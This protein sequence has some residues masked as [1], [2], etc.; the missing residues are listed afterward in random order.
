MAKTSLLSVAGAGAL[1][2][3]GWNQAAHAAPK[4]AQ[5][6]GI[7][8]TPAG[9]QLQPVGAGQGGGLKGRAQFGS[10][11]PYDIAYAYS[12]GRTL[13]T[14]D[15]DSPG[16]SKCA[17]DC[18]KEWPAAI[19]PA[20]ARASGEW[21]VIK[22]K[23]GVPQWAYRGRPLY[24][25]NKDKVPGAVGGKLDNPADRRGSR[26]E[27]VYTPPPPLPKGWNVALFKPGA[28]VPTPPGLDLDEVGDVNG[29]VLRNAEGLTIYAYDGNPNRDG[30]ACAKGGN[31]GVTWVPVAAP[32]GATKAIGEFSP[33]LRQDGVRQW[34]F[35]GKAL[36]TF[37]GDLAPRYANGVGVDA[38]WTPA[39]V[40]TFFLPAGVR[41]ENTAGQGK[42]LATPNGQTLYRRDAH[43]Y[44]TGGGHSLR[45]GVVM[46]PAVGRQLGTKVCEGS[47][48]EKW[49]PFFASDSDQPSG[50]WE[51]AQRGDGSRQWAYRGFPLYTYVG[52]TKP[53][54]INGN[55]IYEMF[56]GSDPNAVN[57]VGTEQV[58]IATLYWALAIP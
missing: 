35:R 31:C 55:D 5:D 42:I 21:S 3:L 13:Y 15:E 4:P 1:L 33:I 19:A 27:K 36:Y 51:I 47:C 20:N 11:P 14:S 43:A 24:M 46:R 34:S 45:H 44:Q 25:S 54:D 10:I 49:T 30:T 23:D 48:L 40:K 32:Q 50:Y 41:I 2:L 37:A 18:A 28:D 9:I 56:L 57:T 6:A 16:V 52:D 53:G 22:R 26:N 38:H 39:V 8:A 12:D 29:V 17:D 58:G 7:T